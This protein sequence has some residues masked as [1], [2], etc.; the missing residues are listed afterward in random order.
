MSRNMRIR[1][2]I[3]QLEDI[4]EQ[5]DDNVVVKLAMQPSWPFEYSIGDVVEVERTKQEKKNGEPVVCFLGEGTQLGYLSGPAAVALGW[6]EDSD[7][8]VCEHCG[9]DHDYD[10]DD[11]ELAPAKQQQAGQS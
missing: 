2:L 11:C 10:D 8:D 4:A 1:D 9:G 7:E 3:S 6:R 5:H